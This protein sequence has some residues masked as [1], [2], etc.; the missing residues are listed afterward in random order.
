MPTSPSTAANTGE[1]TWDQMFAIAHEIQRLAK[2]V[3]HIRRKKR[4]KRQLPE[5]PPPKKRMRLPPRGRPLS[6]SFVT[7]PLDESAADA[8]VEES[9]RELGARLGPRAPDPTQIPLGDEGVSLYTPPLEEIDPHHPTPSLSWRALQ[10]ASAPHLRCIFNQDLTTRATGRRQYVPNECAMAHLVPRTPGTHPLY[11]PGGDARKLSYSNAMGTGIRA[12]GAL[13]TWVTRK[14]MAD[15]FGWKRRAH[16]PNSNLVGDE[17]TW[18][19][20]RDQ[21]TIVWTVLRSEETELQLPHRDLI[22]RSGTVLL[23]N[24]DETPQAIDILV[25]TRARRVELAP[26]QLLAWPGDRPHRGIGRAG[27]RLHAYIVPVEYKLLQAGRPRDL[28]CNNDLGDVRAR[29]DRDECVACFNKRLP[30]P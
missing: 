21:Y 27:W 14:M 12:L 4:E 10:E 16:G 1:A 24:I 26:G 2:K 11:R 15:R 30:M 5:A 29:C 19:E 7:H 18:T 9:F 17:R 25:G 28:D 3:G 8:R 6:V 23:M 20:R 22:G 13:E